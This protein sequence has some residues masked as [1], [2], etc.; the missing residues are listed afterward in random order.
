M[1]EATS[2]VT[3]YRLSESMNHA[4]HYWHVKV[5]ASD[6]VKMKYTI[7]FEALQTIHFNKMFEH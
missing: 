7:V 1:I 6:I 4:T 2:K 3:P 5:H